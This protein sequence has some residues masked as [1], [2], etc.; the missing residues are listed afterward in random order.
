MRK[1]LLIIA[2]CPSPNTKEMAA[3]LID[4]ANSSD[5]DSVTV[6][7]KSPFDCDAQDVLQ[8]DALILFTTENFAYMSGALKDLFDRIYY[9]C[10]NDE[11]RNDAKPFSVVIKAGLDG[12]GTKVAVHKI[13]TGLRWKKVSPTIICKGPFAPE[14][15]T[16]CKELGQ[17]MAVSLDTG[18]I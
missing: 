9:T 6:Q 16:Q 3:A 5:L 12:A 10:I 4:G 11:K 1:K 15:I 18:I 13:I 8:A 14:F 17:L 7:L 2:H